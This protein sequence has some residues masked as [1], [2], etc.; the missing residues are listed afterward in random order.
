M[1]KRGATPI[2]LMFTVLLFI[3]FWATFLGRYLITIGYNYINT[4]SSTGV[5]ALFFA[6]L[7]FVV[8]IA[9]ILS[10]GLYGVYG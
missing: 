3:I 1:D 2:K 5:E 4:N 7:N 9:L 6:N 8:L 10:I